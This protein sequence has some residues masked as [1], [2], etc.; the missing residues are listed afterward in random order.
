ML[1]TYNT[2]SQSVAVNGNVL[3]STN[4]IITGSTA[5]HSAGTAEIS[6]NKPGFYMVTVDATIANP[7]DAA[8]NITLE[9]FAN[10]TAVNGAE[11]TLTSTGATD[12]GAMSFTTIIKVSP[13]CS[14]S[15]ANVPTVLTVQNTGV[16]ST[17]NNA[18]VTVTKLC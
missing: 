16:A 3:F 7:G 11:A 5:T 8:A 2:T 13:N 4:G 9:L 18:A 15:T 14:C 12:L 6:L 1:Y 17:V 10:G